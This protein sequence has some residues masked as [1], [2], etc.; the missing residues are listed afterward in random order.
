M[1]SFLTHPE[2]GMLL[3]YLDGEL[4]ARKSRQ[5]RGHLEA[6]WQCRTAVE[7][8]ETTVASCVHYRKNVLQAH[9]PPPPA[10]WADLSEGFARIDSEVGVESWMARFG[11]WLAAPA[12]RRWA[13][14]GTAALLLAAGL[15]YQFRE[16]PSVQA[17]KN[18]RVVDRD[19]RDHQLRREQA[20]KHVAGNAACLHEF[21]GRIAGQ[22]RPIHRRLDELGLDVVEVDFE[23]FLLLLRLTYT[24]LE[25]DLLFAEGPNDKSL[26][27]AFGWSHVFAQYA[28]RYSIPAS[29]AGAKDASKPAAAVPICHPSAMSP[30]LTP[31]A[32][33]R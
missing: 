20:L 31:A 7:D 2:D 5:V 22:P 17:A 14:S 13:L 4:P 28:C 16:T 32:A 10:P 11:H 12:A 15:F 6:C 29:L 9:L 23:L 24:R 27:K 26:R 30:C 1:S 33:L 25:Q 18:V 3:R 21:L 19:I 8:L